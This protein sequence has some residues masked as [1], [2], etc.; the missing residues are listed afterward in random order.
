MSGYYND[1]SIELYRPITA[2]STGI[3]LENALKLKTFSVL[4]SKELKYTN[5][6]NL[7]YRKVVLQLKY[8]SIM[9][10]FGG[11]MKVLILSS[12]RVLLMKA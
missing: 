6:W 1:Q 4:Y 9:G 2:C 10:K 5:D 3:K 8:L 7:V 12:E 11:E